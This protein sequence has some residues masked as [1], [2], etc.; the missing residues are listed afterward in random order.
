MLCLILSVH[1]TQVSVAFDSDSLF[2]CFLHLVPGILFSPGF[3]LS[4]RI[5]PIG[6]SH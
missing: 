2:K 4:P 3:F 1:H 6:L 5:L